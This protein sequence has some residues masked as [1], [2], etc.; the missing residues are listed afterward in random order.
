[1][2][3]LDLAMPVVAGEQVFRNLQAIDRMWP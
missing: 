3:L 1:V 2:V